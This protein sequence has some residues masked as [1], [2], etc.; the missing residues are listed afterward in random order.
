MPKNTCGE[1]RGWG[2]GRGAE[3]GDQGEMTKSEN[4]TGETV[5][6]LFVLLGEGLIVKDIV[7]E[8]T[9]QKDS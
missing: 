3:E 2:E 1:Q 9:G 7:A 6:F 5:Y 4:Q 8:G